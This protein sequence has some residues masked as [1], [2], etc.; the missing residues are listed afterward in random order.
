MGDEQIA[1]KWPMKRKDV[2]HWKKRFQSHGVRGLWDGQI[3][4]SDAALKCTSSL[5][6]KPKTTVRSVEIGT[7]HFACD[8]VIET[9]NRPNGGKKAVVT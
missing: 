7:P 5:R 3:T 9:G 6:A 8:G 4:L 2:L 1:A